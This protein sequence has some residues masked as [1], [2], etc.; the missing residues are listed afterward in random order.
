MA[1]YS[2]L[3]AGDKV[4]VAVSGGK[5]SAIMLLVFDMIQRKAPFVFSYHP[6]LIDQ[7]HPG[8]DPAPYINWFAA[9]DITI[10]LIEEDTYSIVKEKLAADKSPCGLCSRLRRGI[11]YTYAAKNGFTKIALG[12]HRDDLNET[13]L[14][15]LFF[16]GRIASMPPKLLSDDKRNTVIRPLCY[17]PEEDLLALSS[18]LAIPVLSCSGCA[19]DTSL[20]RV[21]VKRL[22]ATLEKENASLRGSL[23]TA[24][25][26]VRPSQLMDKALWQ[27]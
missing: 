12:H 18:E 27:F 22:I 7:K 17:V 10:D 21:G 15:N 5:D 9:R 19:D 14:L 25:S 16:S 13:L 26:N 2:M 11:L 1:D 3:A 8:F 20:Q 6:V 4:L 23:F 24:Q